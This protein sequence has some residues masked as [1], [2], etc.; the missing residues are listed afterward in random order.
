MSDFGEL[1]G[2]WDYSTLPGNVRIGRDCFLECRSSFRRFR[3]ERDPGLVLGARVRA[4]G[5]TAFTSE[6]TGM[7]E[8]GDDTVL[9]GAVFWCAER[10]SIGRRVVVSYNVILADSDFHPRD[11]DVRRLDTMAISPG[12]NTADR[13]PF[14]ARPIVIEDDVTV[15]IGAIILKGVRIGAGASVM[16]GAVVSRD[17]PPGAVVAGNPARIVTPAEVAP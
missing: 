15:G 3:S 11:P 6:P 17:V 7:I 8:V 14:P 1:T 16:A 9:A 12:G 10:I 5:W 13:P 4:Y 2:Q